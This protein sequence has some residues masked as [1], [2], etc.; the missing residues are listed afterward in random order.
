MTQGPQAICGRVVLSSPQQRT[1]VLVV[2]ADAVRVV[3]RSGPVPSPGDIV[4]VHLGPATSQGVAAPVREALDVEVLVPYP[5]RRPFPDPH[6]DWY[7]FH[8]HGA[9]RWHALHRRAAILAA[10]RRWFDAE[11]FLEVQTPAVVPSPG[12]DVHL[13]ACDVSFVPGPGE[14]ARRWWL[15]T[16][17]E[18][19]MKRLLVAGFERIYQIGRAH[20]SGERGRWHEPEFTIAEWYR[21]YAPWRRIV[22]DVQ[23]LVVAAA[24][25]LHGDVRVPWGDATLDLSPPWPVTTLREAYVRWAGFDPVPW[26]DADRLRV[27]AQRA[28]IDLGPDCGGDASAILERVLV[29]RIEPALPRDRPVVV[30]GY[31]MA[32]A[33]LARADDADPTIAQRFEIYLGGVELANGFGELIDPIEQRRRFERDRATRRAQGLAVYPIDER[34]VA[35]L[36]EGCPPASGVALGV[37]RLVAVLT[38]SDG[39]ADTMA[40]PFETLA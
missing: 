29:D 15:G 27:R 22:E 35:A 33:S 4:R 14:P 8:A 5:G 19:Q 9:R 17:P 11:G 10:M 12:L 23:G 18:Y 25:A 20:R 2:Q 7:R 32:M 1:C 34:F 36:E 16:S 39:V 21:A 31:P 40:F 24:Q 30:W 38:G 6:G 3:V 28:G 37:D 13:T 26:D